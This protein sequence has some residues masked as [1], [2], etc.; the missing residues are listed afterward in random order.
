MT[1][2]KINTETKTSKYNV[3]CACIGSKAQKTKI[4][5]V[6]KPKTIRATSELLD[7]FV[8]LRFW[9]FGFRLNETMCFLVFQPKSKKHRVFGFSPEAQQIPAEK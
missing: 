5:K 6:Q 7:F 1:K 3:C 4:P 9:F 2:A 8:F